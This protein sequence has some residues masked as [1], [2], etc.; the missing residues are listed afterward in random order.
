MR[1][2]LLI[3]G[4]GPGGAERVI[5]LLADAL[6][7]RGHDVWLITLA[8]SD[9]D[10]F[11]V[12]PR[13]RRLGLGLR[14]DSGGVAEALLANVRRLRALRRVISTIKP[15]VVLSFVTGMNVLVILACIGLSARVVV[16]ER[17][18]PASHRE[19]RAW[20]WLRTLLYRRADA[21]VVQT[22]VVA[23]WFRQRLGNRTAVHVIPNP[24]AAAGKQAQSPVL[25]PTPFILA[26][27]R[28]VPQKG[29]DILIRAF[30]MAMPQC[31]QLRL[32]IAGAGPSAAELRALVAELQIDTRVVFVGQVRELQ[33]LMQQAQSFVLSSRYEGFPNVLLEALANGL[34]VVATDCPSGPREIL[35]GG[36]F[37]LLVPCEDPEA[38]ADGLRRLATDVDLRLRLS[39]GAPLAIAPYALSRVVGEWEALFQQQ[40]PGGPRVT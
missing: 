2:A 4:L 30:A 12:E 38:L 16:S 5:S 28:L 18:D 24:V 23:G 13:V 32:A 7:D 34:P 20:D 21:I 26:A 40:Q 39:A 6:V 37:G 19:L 27:G 11:V 29:F 17:I 36:Q 25:V 31:G 8:A 1:I 10:F 14:A 33:T 9:D 35:R 15:R 3:S 22:E